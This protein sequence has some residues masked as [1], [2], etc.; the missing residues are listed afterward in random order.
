MA[1]SVNKSVDRKFSKFTFYICDWIIFQL[2]NENKLNSKRNQKAHWDKLRM[3]K[4]N[5]LCVLLHTN[6]SLQDLYILNR[7]INQ[8]S[9]KRDTGILSLLSAA[10]VSGTK[11]FATITCQCKVVYG[12]SLCLSENKSEAQFY[13]VKFT[14]C[15][16]N[17]Y[18][19]I[20]ICWWR[21]LHLDNLIRSSRVNNNVS[22]YLLAI[23]NFIDFCVS[24]FG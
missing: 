7:K 18:S 23:L 16:A 20:L 14:K 22:R 15:K 13:F 17:I 9:P 11:Y 6:V 2:I 3:L 5:Y 1:V 8:V 4:I 21:P 24:F 12:C 10:L 19:L